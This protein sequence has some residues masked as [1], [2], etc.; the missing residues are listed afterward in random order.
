MYCRKKTRNN[1]LLYN[2]IFSPFQLHVC[3]HSTFTD[4]NLIADSIAEP[5]RLY[6][7]SSPLGKTSSV[8]TFNDST[9]P[10]LTKSKLSDKLVYIDVLSCNKTINDYVRAGDLD[11]A[12]ELFTRMTVKTTVTWNSILAGYSRKPGKVNEARQL[13]DRIPE[14]TTVSFNTMLACYLNNSDVATARIFFNQ[15][16]VKDTASYNTLI[17]GLSRNGKMA[18]AHRI[19]S[20]MPEKNDVSWNAMI[21]GNVEA[22]DL[23][24]ALELFQIAPVKTVIAWTAVITGFMK[25]GKIESAKNLFEKM[26]SKSSVSWNAMISGYIDNNQSEEGLKLFKTMFGGG[27]WP[28]ASTLCSALLG[29]SNLSDLKLGKQ[30]HQL[31]FKSPLYFDTTA[32]TSILSMYTKCG[33]LKD[34]WKLFTEISRKD[35]VTWNSMISGFAQHGE[36]QRALSLF[37]KMRIDGKTQPDWI[38]FVAVLSACNHAGLVDLGIQYFS[39]MVKDYGVEAKPDHFACMVDLLGRAGKLNEAVDV[40]NK[41]PFK[42]HPAIYGTLLGACRIHKN[43]ELAEFAAKNLLNLQPENATGYVQLANVYASLNKWTHVA[44][45]RKSMKETNIVKAPGYSWIEVKN[46]I[47]EFRSSD[48]VHRDLDAIHQKLH[49]LDRKIRVAGYVPDLEFAL[50]DVEEEQKE[51]ILLRH[52][53]K[54]AIAYALMRIPLGIPIRVFKNLRVC[55]DCHNAIKYIS[56]IENREIIVRDTTRFHHF[57]DG[58]CSCGDYW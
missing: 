37:D 7:P 53:E 5:A 32:G 35:I 25:F 29:C 40:I 43:I 1:Y 2:K 51:L 54:L 41:M 26:P 12:L 8:P 30:I 39:S 21:S 27:F 44:S 48:R 31:I 28:N 46:V 13:F 33:E 42:P 47:H 6:S 45:I 52:S 55:R 56:A 19:F 20:I 4:G 58:I 9:P 36:G 22:G 3:S 50:H 23:N 16:P 18:E 14:P 57:K 10:P 11:S 38:T 24:S 15:I 17:S 34:A 49:D